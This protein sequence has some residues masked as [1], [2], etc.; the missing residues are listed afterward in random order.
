MSPTLRSLLSLATIASAAFA[1]A[2]DH[3]VLIGTYTGGGSEG[4]YA[5]RLNAD[6]GIVS[7]PELAAELADPEFLA[8]HPNGRFVYALTRV[9]GQDGK[10]VAAVKA[11]SVDPA[12][13]KLAALNVESTGRSSLT[14]LAV[15]PTGRMLVAASYNGAYVVSFPI[16]PDGTLGT[17]A[18]LLTHQG[19]LGPNRARQDAPHPHSVTIAPDGR[20]AFVADLGLDR[21]FSYRLDPEKGTLTPNDPAFAVMNPGSGPRHTKFSPGGKFFYVLAELAG[22]VTS[23]R[24]D[25]DR[26]EIEPVQ[27]VSTLPDDFAG[28]N[29][30][31]E[32]RIRDDGHFVYAANRGPNTIAVFARDAGTGKLTRIEIVP[33]GGDHPRN[34]ALSPDGAWLLCAH[35]NTNNLTVF[36]VGASDGELTRVPDE[37]QVSKPVCVLF[38]R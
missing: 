10:S 23:C 12:T 6:S 25:S 17:W 8:L 16:H 28:K 19:V 31:S 21:V 20:F 18:S 5:V 22:T 35:Q 36:R 26:G 29:T 38:V 1:R 32:I 30:S 11:F 27:T 34:F 15:D 14:H 37:A 7:K 3:V 24:Y 13:G 4:I 9:A 2:G 33:T